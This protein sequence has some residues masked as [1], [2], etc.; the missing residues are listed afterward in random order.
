MAEEEDRNDRNHRLE[1]WDPIKVKNANVTVVGSGPLA[2]YLITYIAGLGLGKVRIISNDIHDARNINEFLVCNSELGTPKVESLARE[3]RRLNPDIEVTPKNVYVDKQDVGLNSVEYLVDATNN[4]DSKRRCM[5]IADELKMEG[6][7][8]KYFISASTSRNKGSVAIYSPDGSFLGSTIQEQRVLSDSD[9]LIESMI[10]SGRKSVQQA[11]RQSGG[12]I[13]EFVSKKKKPQAKHANGIDDSVFSQFA[14]EKE[15]KKYDMKAAETFLMQEY[16]DEGQGNVTSGVI[17]AVI[18]DEIRKSVIP[19]MSEIAEDSSEGLYIKF[20]QKNNGKAVKIL[21]NRLDYNLLSNGRFFTIDDIAAASSP[22]K[23]ELRNKT[24]V[25]VGGGGI[26]TYAAL[27]LTIMGIGEIYL[28]EPDTIEGSN[29]NRQFLYVGHNGEKK[30]QV[31]KEELEKINPKLRVHAVAEWVKEGTLERVLG[32][33]RPDI[34]MGCVDNWDARAVMNDFAVRNKIPY[35][36]GSL[37]PFNGRVESYHPNETPC[38]DCQSGYKTKSKDAKEKEKQKFEETAALLR[39]DAET[40][41]RLRKYIST[42]EGL[43][44]AVR[45]VNLCRNRSGSIVVSNALVGTLMAAEALTH[46]I[47]SSY[48]NPL[49]GKVLT[50][51]SILEERLK[52]RDAASCACDRVEKKD[53]CSCHVKPL[54]EI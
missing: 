28:I 4:P 10:S 46:L 6:R 50:Y 23:D 42:Q 7:K 22:T 16:A 37:D 29:Y 19:R 31:M 34:I 40:N 43:A 47:P 18:L 41:E 15:R 8:I 24:A 36:D 27:N 17:A 49:R 13:D 21:A 3:L 26:G 35:I 5:Q 30:A 11:L 51:G 45:D 1:A 54:Y 39:K 52:V 2:N 44:A 33:Q 25:V 53:R 9:S 20:G 38:L 14:K 32:K 48:S 12:Y